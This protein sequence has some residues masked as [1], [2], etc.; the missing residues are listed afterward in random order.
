MIHTKLLSSVRVDQHRNLH[1]YTRQSQEEG[2][3][4]VITGVRDN[5]LQVALQGKK[6]LSLASGKAGKRDIKSVQFKGG[7]ACFDPKL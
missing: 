1:L 7:P 4:S 6:L 5:T 2:S 3:Q